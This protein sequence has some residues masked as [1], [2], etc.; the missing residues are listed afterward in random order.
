MLLAALGVALGTGFLELGGPAKEV[1]TH[2]V[3]VASG[4]SKEVMGAV[5]VGTVGLLF[6]SR[7]L[8]REQNQPRFREPLN[9]GEDFKVIGRK[10]QI[11]LADIPTAV[12]EMRASFDAGLTLPLKKRMEQ[13]K[14]LRRLMVENEE[15]IKQAVV[16]DLGRP[17][18]ETMVYDFMLPIIEIEHTMARLKD[19]TA[20]RPVSDFSLLSFPSSQWLQPEPYGVAL[21]IGTWNFPVMLSITPLLGAIAAGNTVVVKPCNVARHTSRLQA[22]LISKYLDPRIVTAIGSDIDGDRHTTSALLNEKFDVIFFTGSPAVGKVVAMG[23]A[24]HLSK[25]IL[26]LG[27]KNPVVVAADADVEKA[28]KTVVWARLMNGGQQCVSPD[29]VLCCEE[30]EPQFTA[31]CAKYCKQLYPDAGRTPGNMGRIV[32]DAQMKRLV[33]LLKTHGGEVVCG[34]EYDEAERYIAPTVVKV[35]HSSSLM[36]DEIFGPILPVCV[37]KDIPEALAYIRTRPKPLS[38]Y[39]YSSSTRVQ[40][41]CL[42]N[43]SA[44]GVTINGCLFHA[45]HASLPFGGVG[46]S[47]Q[48]AYHGKHTIESF[49]HLKP[50]LSRT[51][52][53]DF[54]LLSDPFF[55]YPPWTSLKI[56]VFRQML[57]MV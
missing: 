51:A 23:A 53:P 8:L 22:E 43:T 12:A 31:A 42:A 16:A 15:A 33:H 1:L 39:V 24:Q 21:V 50:C 9:V 25:C 27:G 18:G 17:W 10:T 54:G 30:V 29:Y 40:D 44:G 4:T 3:G 48:G 35:Q 36:Q 55:L 32:G 46:E 56:G 5:I 37:V 47:G 28:A 45:G 57:K 13:L 49:Q 6:A 2:V 11:Q 7:L 26:E 20:K 14:A 38:M 41:E 52:L 34:G 19:M